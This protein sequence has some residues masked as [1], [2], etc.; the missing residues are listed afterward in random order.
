[1]GVIGM[2]ILCCRCGSTP[3]TSGQA[4]CTKCGGLTST[5][6]WM[7]GSLY[8]FPQL[9][10]T[11]RRSKGVFK[12]LALIAASLLVTLLAIGIVRQAIYD[13]SPEGRAALADREKQEAA[14]AATREKQNAEEAAQQREVESKQRIEEVER[15]NR[16]IA[17]TK[18][19]AFSAAALQNIYEHNEV[20][21]DA[22]FKGKT[23]VVRGRVG[24]IA[25]DIVDSPFI[26]LDEGEFGLG[27]VQ[28]FFD[29]SQEPRLALLSP[30]ESLYVRGTVEGKILMSVILKA[31]TILE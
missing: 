7:N 11:S 24:R 1:M 6:Q 16:Q 23:V 25:K 30:G 8:P 26:T 28:C 5:H 17:E 31:S 19:S 27:S 22:Q 4:Y 21:A 14:E 10:T 29:R 13:A 18:A 12:K 3:V 2:T 9:Q 20:S 15:R